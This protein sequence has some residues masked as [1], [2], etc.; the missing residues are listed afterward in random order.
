ML[1][2]NA[3]DDYLV[4]LDGAGV[5]RG[6]R[7]L[8]RGV[9]FEVRRG[10]I[11]TMIGPNGSGKSTSARMAIGLVRPDEGEVM[12]RAGLRVGYVPQ[13]M[14]IDRTMPLTVE[15]LMTLTG[16]LPRREID[17]ALS[18]TGIRHLARSEVQVLSGGE[19]QRAL[20]ARAIARKPDL[21][22]LD[23]PVQGVDFSG[24]IALYE[25]ITDI[26]DR[27]GCGV[28]LIS[29]D[30]HVVMAATD[31]VICMNG[32]VCCRGAPEVVSQSAE[33]QSLFGARAA[34]ALAL[35]SHRHDHT[36]LPDG[37]V[38]H[39]DGSVTDHC[40]PED[41]HHPHVHGP[42]CGCGHDHARL[43]RPKS[44]G[45]GVSDAR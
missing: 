23:E 33:Y 22:V 10:E 9:T 6:G 3:D 11:V 39:E 14:S 28:L 30:L 36:H 40:H 12:T 25:L 35:Y 8:V 41:G 26:R 24:E 13:K 5:N 34:G 38:L 31:T 21:L 18:E 29:H 2:R 4:S 1:Q 45:E 19:F 44:L 20:L 27:S 15:R 17:A 42:D 37:R 32:H 43:V 7:W 16:P